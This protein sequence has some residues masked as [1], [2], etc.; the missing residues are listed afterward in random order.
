MFQLNFSQ[1]KNEE[2]QNFGDDE[3]NELCQTLFAEKQS[4]QPTDEAKNSTK[5]N[6]TNT[7]VPTSERKENIEIII[8]KVET[9]EKT[10]NE[11]KSKNADEQNFKK[12]FIKGIIDLDPEIIPKG[13]ESDDAIPKEEDSLSSL[14]IFDTNVERYNHSMYIGLPSHGDENNENNRNI[15]EKSYTA[16]DT[17]NNTANVS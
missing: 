7:D 17:R 16:D 3:D 5:P 11:A 10:D 8:K 4:H 14:P 2:P 13:N 9:Q 1:Q 6:N 12:D 15:V